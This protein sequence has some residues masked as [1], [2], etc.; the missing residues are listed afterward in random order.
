METSRRNEGRP[1]DLP[2]PHVGTAGVAAEEA[3]GQMPAPPVHEEVRQS[4]R[5]HPSEDI[6]HPGEETRRRTTDQP[7]GISDRPSRR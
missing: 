5:S 1:S 3:T 6:E 7:T 4:E 2:R